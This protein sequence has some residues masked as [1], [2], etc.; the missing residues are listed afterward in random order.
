MVQGDGEY[1][2]AAKPKSLYGTAYPSRRIL[3]PSTTFFLPIQSRAQLSV[4]IYLFCT[5]VGSYV[6][7]GGPGGGA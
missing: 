7:G 6:D 1:K 2:S 3:P 4:R 5:F